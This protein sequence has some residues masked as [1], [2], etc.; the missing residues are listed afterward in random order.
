MFLIYELEIK[1]SS[2][3]SFWYSEGVMPVTFLKAEMKL[4]SDLK[5]TLSAMPCML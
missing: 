5:P 1:E 4:E 3:D 2:L